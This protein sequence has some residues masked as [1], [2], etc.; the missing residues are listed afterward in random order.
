MV[1]GCG[2]ERAHSSH[3]HF[4]PR[5]SPRAKPGRPSHSSQVVGDSRPTPQTRERPPRRGVRRRD[6]ASAA[7]WVSLVRHLEVNNDKMSIVR[8]PGGGA[9]LRARGGGGARAEGRRHQQLRL[10][11]TRVWRE[12]Q[13]RG[14]R[15]SPPP[16]NPVLA[17]SGP[18]PRRT[19]ARP[20]PCSQPL[21][22]GGDSRPA[23]DEGAPAASSPR[24]VARLGLT[25]V[26]PLVRRAAGSRPRLSGAMHSPSPGRHTEREGGGQLWPYV[27]AR[28]PPPPPPHHH[29]TPPHTHHPVQGL[30]LFL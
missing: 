16:P 30:L 29:H 28:A 18:T 25:T 2:C 8:V 3:Q 22:P 26:V 27:C 1:C 20:T 14:G 9:G 15:F 7:A 10:T 11:L 12:G 6:A 13:T 17:T 23:A 5:A 19:P 21:E 24:F 4:G